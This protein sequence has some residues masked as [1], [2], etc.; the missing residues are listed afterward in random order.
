VQRFD[1]VDATNAAAVAAIAI[2]YLTCT[3]FHHGHGMVK[4]NCH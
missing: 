1:G 3:F 4:A 2:E